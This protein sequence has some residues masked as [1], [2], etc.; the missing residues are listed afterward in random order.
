[1]KKPNK[2]SKKSSSVAF[3]LRGIFGFVIGFVGGIIMH[4][5]KEEFGVIGFALFI[6][7][8]IF[9]LYAQIILHEGGHLVFGL[10]SGYKFSS[11]RVGSIV[12]LK[13]NNKYSIKRMTIPGTGGQC[14]MISPESEDGDIPV[15]LYNFG[16]SI[17]N[18]VSSIICLLIYL[19]A[20]PSVFFSGVLI[21]LFVI[22]VGLALIN[23][24]PL[25]ANGVDN[26]GYNALM[27]SKNKEAREAF[28]F[29]LK[30]NSLTL[31][32][33]RLKDMDEA[34]FELPTFESMKNN[35]MIAAKGVFVCNRLMDMH[36]FYE[37]KALMNK[38]INERT[39]MAGIHSLLLVCDIIYCEAIGDGENREE[40]IGEK[41]NKQQERFMNSMKNFLSVIRTRFAYALLI[42]GDVK[43]AEKWEKAF[44]KRARTNPY[45]AD[46]ESE[47]ELIATAKSKYGL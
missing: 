45:S 38:M 43:E 13:K 46:I 30:V 2:N 42:K 20:P 21:M 35:T 47:R 8:F 39:N 34:L 26:D 37:A 36:R 29:Q 16:G 19:F 28:A 32:G 17:V 40:V 6:T 15:M 23:G 1:M 33:V 4:S 12:L 14:L 9:C 44:E 25:R 11:F 18:A 10:I 3:V 41:M 24:I 27:L 5:Y 22:G 7:A 31:E